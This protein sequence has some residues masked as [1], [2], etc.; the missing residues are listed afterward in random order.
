MRWGG[1]RSPHLTEPSPP[2]SLPLLVACCHRALGSHLRPCDWAGR[3]VR[4]DPWASGRRRCPT[5]K[6]HTAGLLRPQQRPPTFSVL[7]LL[8]GQGLCQCPIS[9]QDFPDAH[10]GTGSQAW[11]MSA[12]GATEGPPSLGFQGLKPAWQAPQGSDTMGLPAPLALVS[13]P[14]SFWLRPHTLCP[15]GP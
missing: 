13:N 9:S 3:G 14:C 1:L 15:P 6:G 12:V 2:P 5:Q 4:L 8:L 11:K 10:Q 7:P